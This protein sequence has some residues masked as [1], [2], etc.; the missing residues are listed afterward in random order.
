MGHSGSG[1]GRVD[2]SHD[3]SGRVDFGYKSSWVIVWSISG[4]VVSCR[5][6]FGSM[7]SRFG[8]AKDFEFKVN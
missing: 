2:T 4:L 6:N 7:S 5:A 1:L 8:S 3:L